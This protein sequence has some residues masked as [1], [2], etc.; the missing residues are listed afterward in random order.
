M[1]YKDIWFL[2]RYNSRRLYNDEEISIQLFCILTTERVYMAY[3]DVVAYKYV[4]FGRITYTV[5]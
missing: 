3:N 4:P 1:A 5:L 2:N